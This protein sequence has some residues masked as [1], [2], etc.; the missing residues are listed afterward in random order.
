MSCIVCGGV[1]TDFASES[2]ILDGV[3]G[4]FDRAYCVNGHR[5]ESFVTEKELNPVTKTTDILPASETP[6]QTKV[7]EALAEAARVA[8]ASER[9]KRIADAVEEAR[10]AEQDRLTAITAG[11]EEKIDALNTKLD[12]TVKPSLMSRILGGN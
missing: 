8:L 4:F 3:S 9:E 5:T 7:R 12:E 1:V 10:Q 11:I 2:Y 6:E